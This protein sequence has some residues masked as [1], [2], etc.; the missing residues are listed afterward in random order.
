[1]HSLGEDLRILPHFYIVM[2][3][4]FLSAGVALFSFRRR[5]IPGARALAWGMIA[6][7]Q[8]TI[9]SAMEGAV[10]DQAAKILWSKIE[11]IG[12]TISFPFLMIFVLIFTQQTKWLN[13]LTMTILWAFPVLTLLLVWTN[14]W[15][16]WIWT[17]FTPGSADTNTLIFLRGSWYWVFVAY[18]YAEFALINFLLLREFFRWQRPYRQQLVA[19]VLAGL[20]PALSGLVYLSD[21]N[22]WP[23][24]NLTPFSFAAVGT[25]FAWSL[26]RLHL[27]D[28]VPVA[29]EALV[30]QLTDGV[31]VLDA[32]DRIVD[33]NPAAKQLLAA[34]DGS[35]IGQ[36]VESLLSADIP[37]QAFAFKST[38]DHVEFAIQHP[39][40]RF[41]ELVASS[42]YNHRNQ[43]TGRL[44]MLRDITGRKQAEAALQQA[45]HRL[46]LQLTR[47]RSL[48]SR[49]KEQ[50]SRD[51]L[52]NLYNRRYL[53][54]VLE[55]ELARARRESYPISLIMID[56][57]HFKQVNDRCGHKAGDL[58]LQGLAKL[59]IEHS[60]RGDVACRYGGEEFMLVM[61]GLAL[62][63]AV[64]RAESWRESFERLRIRYRNTVLSTTI[65]IG[66]AVF[67]DHGGDCEELLQAADQALYMAKAAG[68][69]CVM[70]CE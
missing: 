23:G 26:F 55:R 20:F 13:R 36:S 54:E 42:F 60:R 30:E 6:I 49:L 24:L 70:T 35:W 62:E 11:Y 48:Q 31:I 17:G 18:I 34:A 12:Y 51:P 69:N 32:Q 52:T 27:F 47:I 53:E 40:E 38:Q 68:R 19:I 28:L 43:P 22:P 7:A 67:P 41:L 56:I 33:I 46:G 2:L 65:S 16:G 37:G 58:M 44:I 57:D 10:V 29:R 64:R 21:W 59:L 1:M 61:P 39:K 14:E 5:K 25:V 15:H 3:A 50:A 8:W 9:S 4:A 63:S 45:N 66:A